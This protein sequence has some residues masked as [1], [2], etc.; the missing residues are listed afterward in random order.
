MV[1]EWLFP[2]VRI[3]KTQRVLRHLEEIWATSLSSG[4]LL[5]WLLFFSDV[6]L[7]HVTKDGVLIYDVIEN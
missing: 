5:D 2:S 3:R 7:I 6:I 1:M 4:L